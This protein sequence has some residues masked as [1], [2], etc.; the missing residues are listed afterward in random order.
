MTFLARLQS[1]PRF[2]SEQ[3]GSLTDLVA[4]DKSAREFLPTVPMVATG[5]VDWS[6]LTTETDQ[7]SIGAC[8]G[9]ATADAVEFLNAAAGQTPVQVSRLF[10]YNAARERAGLLQVDS[11]IYIR[12]CFEVLSDIGVCREETWPY[13]VSKVFTRVSMK[14]QREATGH[15]IKG[16]YRIKEEG[17]DRL[18]QIV[19]ALR[20][21]HPVVFGT[22]LG[23]SFTSLRGLGPVT[24]PK[25]ETPLGA[26]A[27]LIVGHISGKG[28]LV[29]NSW[30]RSWG[31][32]G[33][34][35]LTP[36][37]LAW[38]ETSDLWVPTMG[39]E[40]FEAA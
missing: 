21:K 26:H 18:E 28:F 9:N 30:G 13:D 33:F 27:M 12:A 39:T 14:A 40:W 22:T 23:Q 3:N 17:S 10:I 37:Y 25:N 2:R 1:D 16:A 31:E 20:A 24:P 8:A 11:G 5:D 34:C 4:L 29:K 19:S 32:D 38:S 6:S 15:K 35:I 7:L 36:E